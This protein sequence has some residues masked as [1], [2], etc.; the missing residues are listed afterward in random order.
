MVLSEGRLTR[1]AHR[2]APSWNI[3][4]IVSMAAKPEL[5]ATASTILKELI[6]RTHPQVMASVQP[7]SNSAAI[8]PSSS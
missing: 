2:H 8:T 5:Y 6:F 3:L 4:A 7:E 1:V